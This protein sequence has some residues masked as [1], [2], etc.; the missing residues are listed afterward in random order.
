[1]N[2]QLDFAKR[3]MPLY[4]SHKKVR[5]LKIESV[6]KHAHPDPSHNDAE[7]ESS[8][9]FAGAHLFFEKRNSSPCLTDDGM[10]KTPPLCVSADWYRRH[11]PVAGGYYV[12]YEDGYASYS[13]AEPFEA[14]YSPIPEA[15]AGVGA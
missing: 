1:M 4:Q 13:P 15:S 5:A 10:S 8:S 2:E 7:F 12:V 9:E 11:K 6:V 3:H 14:G